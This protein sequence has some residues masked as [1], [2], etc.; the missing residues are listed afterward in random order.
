[1]RKF[2]KLIFSKLPMLVFNS[3]D[4]PGGGELEA[5]EAELGGEAGSREAE[6]G[7]EAGSRAAELGGEAGTRLEVILSSTAFNRRLLP[8]FPLPNG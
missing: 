3:S 5:N 2:Q 6:P 1:M 4:L 7:G 8:A